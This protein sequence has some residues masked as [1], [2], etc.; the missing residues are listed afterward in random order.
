MGRVGGSG[1]CTAR[2]WGRRRRRGRRRR[3][4]RRSKR[5]RG[6]RRRTRRRVQGGEKGRL[7]PHSVSRPPESCRCC[8]SRSTNSNSTNAKFSLMNTTMPL[9]HHPPA[10]P[11][12]LRGIHHQGGAHGAINSKTTNQP[13]TKL[14]HLLAPPVLRNQRQI[15]P[16]AA[17][18]GGA[19]GATQVPIEKR[20][21]TPKN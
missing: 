12:L 14:Y 19:C 21:Q 18:D 3:G 17:E 20:P 5:R 10:P 8:S 6:R 16:H 11:V 15:H 1:G 7:Q 2:G 9:L 13:K 4:R